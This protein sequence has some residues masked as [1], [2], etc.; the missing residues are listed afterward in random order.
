MYMKQ[1]RQRRL[2]IKKQI[3]LGK[4]HPYKADYKALRSDWDAVLMYLW[5][6]M[7]DQTKLK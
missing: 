2:D 7:S 1:L 4:I 3:R 6:D 5:R